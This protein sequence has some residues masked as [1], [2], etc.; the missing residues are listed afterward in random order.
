MSQQIHKALTVQNLSKIDQKS[1]HI[2]QQ[3]SEDVFDGFWIDVGHGFGV[4]F[5]KMAIKAEKGNFSE[6]I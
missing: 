4:F 1:N 6:I 5:I 2:L 3:I